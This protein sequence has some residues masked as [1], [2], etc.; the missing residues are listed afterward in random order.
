[1]EWKEI[2]LTLESTDIPDPPGSLP[3][4][5]VLSIADQKLRIQAERKGTI[6]A[7]ITFELE[8][9][10][11]A[12]KNLCIRI[13][14][15]VPDDYE[16]SPWNQPELS[17]ARLEHTDPYGVT[18]Y[19][20]TTFSSCKAYWIRAFSKLLCDSWNIEAIEERP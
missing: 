1:M 11:E 8:I 7:D 4:N 18:P 14:P 9:S 10:K 13:L 15:D 2:P 12:I 16:Y 5:A 3:I 6:G 20:T 19:F 17:T